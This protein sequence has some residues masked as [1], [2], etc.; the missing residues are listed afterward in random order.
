MNPFARHNINHLSV[1][2]L[3]LWAAAPG[4]WVMERL[5]GRKAP[6]GASAHRGTAVEAGIVLALQGG[7]IDEAI[8]FANARFAELTAFS[9]DPRCDRERAALADMVTKGVAL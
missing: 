5:L 6:V 2:S 1:S 3:N 7:S 4:I 9:A 8:E